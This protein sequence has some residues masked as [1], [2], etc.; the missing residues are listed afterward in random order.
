[1]IEKLELKHLCG[2]LPYGLKCQYFGI[3]D[4]LKYHGCFFNDKPEEISDNGMGLKIGELKE[5]KIYKKYWKAYVGTYHAHLKSFVNGYDFKPLLLPLS[6]LIEPMEDGSVP[7]VELAKIAGLKSSEYTTEEQDGTLVV[8]GK[9]IIY[10]GSNNAAKFFFEMETD[11]CYMDKGIEFLDP[12]RYDFSP[13]NNQIQ[14]FE[15]LYSIH[16]DINGLIESGLAIDKRTITTK[17]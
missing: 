17:N 8:F 12:Y 7:I 11:N 3:V 6:A 2:Y 1:M 4:V 16:A 14:L 10:P 9:E 5:I 13:L 15:Y